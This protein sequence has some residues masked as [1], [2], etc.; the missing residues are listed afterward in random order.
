MDPNWAT[1][2]R[3]VWDGR[4]LAVCGYSIYGPPIDSHKQLRYGRGFERAWA[5]DSR[6]P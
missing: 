3:T 1:H 4:M 2:F 5:V 6:F